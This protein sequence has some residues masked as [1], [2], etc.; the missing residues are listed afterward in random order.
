MNDPKSGIAY[1]RRPEQRSEA[2]HGREL[3]ETPYMRR[4]VAFALI[5]TLFASAAELR[6]QQ[7]G[8]ESRNQAAAPGP[9]LWPEPRYIAKAIE[10][11]DKRTADRGEP[12]NGFFLDLGDLITGS[13]FFAAGPGYR[14]HLFGK[15]ALFET[16]AVLSVRLYW[17]AQAGIE[18][19][20]VGHDRVTVGA[21]ALYQDAMRVNYFGVGNDAPFADRSGY[22]LRT[23]DL[24]GYAIIGGPKLALTSRVGWLTSVDVSSMP[25]LRPAYPDT[26]RTFT[27]ASAPGIFSPTSFLHADVSLG[28]DTRDHAK[29][30]TDGGLYQATWSV[31]ADRSSGAHSFQRLDA[32]ATRYVPLASANWVLA[33]R[34]WM[35]LSRAAE[36]NE[37]PFYFMPALGGRNSR[38]YRD[39]RF[40]D[41]NMQA[42]SVESRWAIFDHL[43][44][45]LFVDLGNVAASPRDLFSKDLKRSYGVGVRVHNNRMT[46]GRFDIA[47]SVEG[48]IVTLKMNDPF[49]RSSQ[50]ARLPPVVP[51]VP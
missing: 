31:Y 18:V 19:P 4:V 7:T 46:L 43:D 8:I 34:G 11:F 14:H 15:Q 24:L 1:T 36:G 21:Q 44:A 47:R 51:F 35:V 45:A 16:S 39:Y 20:H 22:R 10:V 27:D 25:V 6:A 23:N 30:A 41:W 5:A 50:S 42:Y 40:H 2:H 33:L 29:H 28:A 26:V 13:G 48:W 3:A 12:G 49:R 32:E 9:G 37:V 17:T 38:G